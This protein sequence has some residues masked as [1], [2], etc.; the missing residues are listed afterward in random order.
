MVATDETRPLCRAGADAA[1]A[2]GT[3]F[4]GEL[5]ALLHRRLRVVALIALAPTA[6]FLLRG[7]AQPGRPAGPLTLD[8]A[9]LEAQTLVEHYRHCPQHTVK[10]LHY[11]AALAVMVMEDLSD[12]RIWRGELIKGIHYPAAAQQL[13]PCHLEAGRLARGL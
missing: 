2:S 6:L 9:R 3:L 5:A 1:A 11:D 13:G 10:V 7:L 4:R 8:R 12:H